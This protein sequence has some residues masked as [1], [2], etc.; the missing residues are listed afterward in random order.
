MCGIIGVWGKSAP[1]AT[2]VKKMANQLDHRG[3]DNSGLWI[4]AS[5]GIALAHQ[6][7]AILDLS[8]A[9]EQPMISSCG[10]FILTYNG[11]IYNHMDLRQELEKQNASVL[12]KGHSDTET[13]LNALSHWGVENT[14]KK[15]NGMFAFAFWDKKKQ[16]LFIARDRMGE[17]PI[18]YGQSK[19]TFFFSSELKAL[20]CHPDWQGEIDR[21]TLSLYLKYNYVPSPLSIYT[22]IKKLPP[23]KFV[24][25]EN[26]G[27]NVSDP[28][29]YWDLT[30]IAEGGVNAYHYSFEEACD[31]LENLLRNAI[32]I[33]M[34]AD[35][36]LGAFLSGGIDSTTVVAMMQAQSSRPIKTFSIGFR[37]DTHNEAHYA[38][39]LAKYLG[40]D[41]N[42]LYVSQQDALSVIPKLPYIYDEPFSDPSQIPTFLVSQLAK[43]HVTV[44]LS[45]DGGDELFC[46]Y[47]RYNM[48]YHVWQK[49]RAFPPSI[50][51][52]VAWL[53]TQPVAY[54]LD[55][56]QKCIP[57][58]YQVSNLPD[59]L[60]KLSLVLKC[61]G[62]DAFYN[63][64]VS[65]HSY[66]EAIVIGNIET[67][68]LHSNGEN[69]PN[70]LDIREKMMFLDMISYLPDGI[71]TKVDRASMAV[72]L[73]ARVPLLD[74]RLVE[75]AW[76]IPMKFKSNSGTGKL[77]LRHVLDRYVPRQLMERPKMGFGIPIEQWLRGS[78]RDWGEELLKE[79]R[80]K[81]EGFFNTQIV[82]KMWEGH[83][84]GLRR[85]HYS[86][87]SI[88]MFQAWLR[89]S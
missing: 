7:L 58:R 73:E 39:T 4:D 8:P 50:R 54:L 64:L 57:K 40:T 9:G 16:Q 52:M 18:Y 12:W 17:K 66:S 42:E 1:D 45:G 2:I 77:L 48:G 51:Q 74:H 79:K 83:Q 82:R 31:E 69:I 14:L 24:I 46:G 63:T 65:N 60:L 19:N 70:F 34:S 56:V 6:R 80:L 62:D 61:E 68:N 22:N 84:R 43:Q 87:W 20:T 41:H 85:W 37:Y 29:S 89:N 32:K 26:D 76:R 27:Q 47:N 28:F 86:L 25:I 23:A 11:E 88:L 59:L 55:L 36:P 44:S 5:D 21:N 71:L 78:L 10:R 13:L 75:F 35:V 3:P 30:Q 49:L 15:I 33:R 81:E 53:I 67:K 72:S 38:K